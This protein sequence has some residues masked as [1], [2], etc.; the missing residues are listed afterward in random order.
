MCFRDK[1]NVMIDVNDHVEYNGSEYVIKAIQTYT[2]ATVAILENI[3]THVVEIP[4]I[5]DIIKL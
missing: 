5:R 2:C 1:N 3:K 4:L